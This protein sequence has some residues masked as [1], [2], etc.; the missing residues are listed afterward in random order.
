[1]IFF[2]SPNQQ[3]QSTEK[4]TKAT[5]C[6]KTLP[7]TYSSIT[8][9]QLNGC[10]YKIMGTHWN[11]LHHYFQCVPRNCIVVVGV[12]KVRGVFIDVVA[13]IFVHSFIITN[14]ANE[15]SR[16]LPDVA[17]RTTSF[18]G[19]SDSSFVAV[20]CSCPI[21]MKPRRRSLHEFVL[22]YD[23]TVA[24]DNRSDPKRRTRFFWQLELREKWT[25]RATA[26]SSELGTSPT[27]IFG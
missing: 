1:M 16:H 17:R 22:F 25:S 23:V 10:G 12:G 20:D 5:V 2:L 26:A 19:W 27:K 7:H 9:S 14:D 8:Y 18:V 3:R 13:M 21:P 24:P 11:A 15:Q 6:S 4:K